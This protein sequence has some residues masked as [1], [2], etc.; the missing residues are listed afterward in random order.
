M[1]ITDAKTC[2]FCG[3]PAV[4]TMVGDIHVFRCGTE[5]P[6]NDGNYD[7]GRVCDMHM[8]HRLLAAKDRE[9]KQLRADTAALVRWLTVC[10]VPLV[11][12]DADVIARLG[13]KR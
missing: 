11:G 5:G 6:D 1:N 4:R 7:T 9:I 10:R 12:L 2:P 8:Y 13:A 3:E